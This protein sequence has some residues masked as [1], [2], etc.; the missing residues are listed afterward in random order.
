MATKPP[1]SIELPSCKCSKTKFPIPITIKFPE[2]VDYIPLNHLD[3]CFD[4]QISWTN[5]R[6]HQTSPNISEKFAQFSQV[7]AFKNSKSS[8]WHLI[9]ARCRDRVNHPWVFS[10]KNGRYSK[11]L[12]KK[13]MS[14]SGYF[15][16]N[17]HHELDKVGPP[18]FDS[19]LGPWK[20][21]STNG[22]H[23]HFLPRRDM[24]WIQIFSVR[25]P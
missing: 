17:P 9:M 7:R 6:R 20:I 25:I 2:C 19:W 24:A 4:A 3:V 13:V 22:I 11:D 5:M 12:P 21:C 18:T 14:S 8:S 23:T 1:T 10:G 15:S 16:I